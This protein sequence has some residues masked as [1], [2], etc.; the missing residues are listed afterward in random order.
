MNSSF[1]DLDTGKACSLT[2]TDSLCCGDEGGQDAGE[3]RTTLATKTT[4]FSWQWD[5]RKSK[6]EKEMLKS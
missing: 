3:G 5:K 2:G 4:V 6:E 1:I